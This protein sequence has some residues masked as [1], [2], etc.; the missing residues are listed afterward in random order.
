ELGILE[1]SRDLSSSQESKPTT[2]RSEVR[3]APRQRELLLPQ[4]KSARMAAKGDRPRYVEEVE[5]KPLARPRQAGRRVSREAEYH[6]RVPASPEA[7]EK[8]LRAALSLADALKADGAAARQGKDKGKMGEGRRG[9]GEGL[10]MV[11]AMV[12][13]HVHG[14]FWLGLNRSFCTAH[15]PRSIA[16]LTLKVDPPQGTADP[17]DST[18]V[19][20]SQGTTDLKDSA[21]L[22]P[23]QGTS[24]VTFD[25]TQKSPDFKSSS[26]GGDS[27][28]GTSGDSKDSTGK[29]GDGDG[30]GNRRDVKAD[31]KR[32]RGGKQ[33]SQE[34]DSEEGGLQQLL[35]ERRAVMGGVYAVGEGEWRATYLPHKTGLSGGWRGFAM[36]QELDAGDAVV[37]EKMGPHTLKVC[38]WVQCGEG[39][40]VQGQAGLGWDM[41]G[42]RGFA[43]DQE[44]D[45]G[46]AV[47]FEKMDPHTLK[48]LDAGDAVV[49]E[50]MDRDTL[51]RGFAMDQ[52]LDAGD[53]VVFEKMDPHTLKVHIFRAADFEEEAQEI[54]SEG[55]PAST[56]RR[57]KA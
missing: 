42:W 56:K 34:G 5:V 54:K 49:F 7:E 36:D 27:S 37:F 15:L 43:M 22:D 14:C 41:M 25:S 24:E 2:P 50:K 18:G 9:K 17:K 40:Y 47:V 39:V 3:R 52:E 10:A 12:R 8:A 16:T 45:A 38:M 46:D 4:R 26:G 55:R 35:G 32:A 33:G 30:E 20:S 19:D 28:Q 48:E 31:R 11:K 51:K 44:L 6:R 23:S 29:K 1:A 53:A 21:Q 13:S 57:M